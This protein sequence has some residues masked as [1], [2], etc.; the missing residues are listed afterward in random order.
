MLLGVNVVEGRVWS[1]AGKALASAV[2]KRHCVLSG[3]RYG[4]TH[5]I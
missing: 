1:S 3:V 2:F 4:V 5:V